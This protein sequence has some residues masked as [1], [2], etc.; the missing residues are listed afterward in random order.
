[1]RDII[2]EGNDRVRSQIKDRV[3]APGYPITHPSPEEIKHDQ[4]VIKEDPTK[5]GIKDWSR[6]F[7]AINGHYY[8]NFHTGDWTLGVEPTRDTGELTETEK[9]VFGLDWFKDTQREAFEAYE[10]WK[11]KRDAQDN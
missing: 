6:G 2:G 1:M 5:T 7:F 11:E 10:G 9:R 3:Y 8:L 4:T